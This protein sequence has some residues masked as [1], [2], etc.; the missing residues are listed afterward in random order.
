MRVN[1]VIIHLLLV[2]A[3][4]VAA[5]EAVRAIPAPLAG[6]PGNIFLHGE[7][8]VVAL[9]AGTGA[10]WRA[11]DYA[12]RVAA[13]GTSTDGRAQ[14]GALPVGYYEIR[15]AE[16]GLANGARVTVGVLAPLAA[17]TPA[18]SPIG[19]DAAM[20]WFFDATTR[21]QA[22]SLCALAGMN[23]VRDRYN[24][25]EIE[26]ERGRI[27]KAESYDD[28][29]R[30]Q[31]A[32]G[33]R[34]LEVNHFSPPWANPDCTR[35]P[36]DLRDAYAITRGLAKR[37]R[38]QVGAFEPWNEA[39]MAMFGGHTGSEMA[40]LQKAAYLG[41]KA[42]NPAALACMN[43]FAL[44][45][46]HVLADLRDNRA[47]SS[48]DTFNLHHYAAIDDYPRIYS[49][50][51]AS[52]AGRPLWVTECNVPVRWTGDP[53]Q[54]E[55]SDAD[56]RIQAERVAT[57]YAS[58]LMQGPELV[59]YFMLPHY[60]EGATQFGV[61]HRDLSPRPA[62][63]AV[64][65]AGR[66]LAGARPL[67][68]W[69]GVP[70][71]VNACVFSA[72]PEGVDREVL[73]VWSSGGAEEV[74][75]PS[76]PLALYDHIGRIRAASARSLPVERAPCYA[77]FPPG[78]FAAAD[79]TAP[80]HP[81][82]RSEGA[83]SRIVLQAVWP[84]ERTVPGASAYRVSAV[85]TESIPVFVYN[86]GDQAAAGELHVTAPAH[87]DAE[88][89][90]HIEIASGERRELALRLTCRSDAWALT[91]AL[92]IDGDFG[93]AGRPVLAMRLMAEPF[94]RRP[95][96]DQPIAGA[97][98]PGRWRSTASAGA[99]VSIAAGPDGGVLVDVSGGA[100]DRWAYPVLDLQADERPAAGTDALGF[101]L[102]ALAG[103]ATY[104]VIFD[105]GNGSSY[106]AELSP[107]A[108][109]VTIEQLALM[110]V[111]SHADA[112]SAADPDGRLDPG[113]IRALR[114]GCNP[115]SEHVRFVIR[116]PAWSSTGSD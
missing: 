41:L 51:R 105:E 59:C 73:V 37:W 79:L 87:W 82:A 114:I 27:A 57:V 34:I 99:T 14:L 95:G 91:E 81:A 24:W 39:D 8:V 100:G 17:P 98:V 63:L 23:W 65:A 36:T 83:P 103:E 67:G 90:G 40:S 106:V 58:A 62:F 11:T 75:M 109:G 86:F 28:A 80:P 44:P 116:H 47:W 52:A 45:Q 113:E 25:S 55:P 92:R 48:F 30:A 26:P 93:G 15:R 110:D 64:A 16:A 21:P 76:A 1:I 78:T 12:G 107:T 115:R 3:S 102:T 84:Q 72:R 54:Q 50:F 10:A 70:D 20:S 49:A 111:A 94:C 68:R 104:R 71:G 42:G 85:R 7:T 96:S 32:A 6:H 53:V 69:L 9:P 38:G 97:E 29:V 4:G 61:L 19:I 56:L 88:L 112:W 46:P 101:T 43:V 5:A 13:E 66:L 108:A 35:F 31:A 89:P 33:L 18:D 74:R 60:A 22:A 77:L 2:A